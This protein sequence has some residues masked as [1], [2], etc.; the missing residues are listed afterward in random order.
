[1]QLNIEREEL[2]DG[3][4]LITVSGD[5]D[6]NSSPTLR[7]ELKSA[8]KRKPNAVH[9]QLKDV[10]YFDSSG[11]AVLIEGKRWCAKKKSV[12][13]LVGLSEKVRGVLELSKL[14]SLFD[15]DEG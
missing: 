10:G 3:V 6:M 12:F 4:I 15:V 2:P 11:I 13:K 5:V 1:M 9:L 7:S 14:L 8:S